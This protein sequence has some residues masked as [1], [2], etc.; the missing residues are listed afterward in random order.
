[1]KK[2][3]FIIIL[4]FVS[5]N[6]PLSDTEQELPNNYMFSYEGGRQNRIVKENQFVIDSEA[7]SASFDD[8][9]IFFQKTLYIL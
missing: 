8:K 7:V 1:M 4:T 2:I 6:F 3:I 9:Y 5:C